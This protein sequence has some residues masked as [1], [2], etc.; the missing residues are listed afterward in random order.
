MG[1]SEAAVYGGILFALA[2]QNIWLL[3]VFL[4]IP[5]IMLLALVRT[6]LEHSTRPWQ[7]SVI[8]N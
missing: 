2:L 4:P 1:L 7:T 6:P 5:L 3:P 8:R